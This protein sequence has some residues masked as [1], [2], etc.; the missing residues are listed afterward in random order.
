[1]T[2]RP[3][4][5]VS[6]EW[7]AGKLGAPDLVVLDASYYL[8][9]QNRDPEAEYRATH[10]P[11]ALRFDI[12]AVADQA[13]TLPHML[14]TADEFAA[15]VG[16]M[17]IAE[18]DTIVVYDG[19]GLFSAPR[20]WWTFRLFGARTVYVLEGGFPRWTA[21]GRPVEAGV[22]SRP[23]KTFTV[24]PPPDAVADVARVQKTIAEKSAQVVDARAADRFT[25]AAPEPRAGLPS[26]HIPGS[27]NVPHAA[28]VQDG[29]LK[30]PDELRAAFQAGG[31]DLDKP[32]LTTCGSGVSAAVL[33]IALHTLGRDPVA[34][35]DGSWTEW[36]GR[37]DL[38]IAT[39]AT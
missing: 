9:T 10:I 38:P 36:A 32:V 14:P 37:G 35:Y 30:S 23:P 31:V 19:L 4:P 8:P 39:G 11:G 3:S 7:L 26:G 17:G 5:F 12:N 13:T 6:T 22:A 28:L 2:A 29:V 1:M 24:T 34:L 16:A 33:W 27:L 25:G 18:T 21:E 15:A 20:V